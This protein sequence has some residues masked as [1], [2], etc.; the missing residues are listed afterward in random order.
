MTK[1]QV[2]SIF[3]KELIYGLIILLILNLNFIPETLEDVIEWTID[4]LMIHL[5]F[6]L[7]FVLYYPHLLPLFQQPLTPHNLT[8]KMSLLEMYL[9]DSQHNF[10]IFLSP[11]PKVR[12]LLLILPNLMFL[13]FHLLLPLN[14]PY[15]LS[16][17]IITL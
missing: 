16:T 15:P 2:L 11:K 4:L 10:L 7:F 3:L 13:H 1:A 12:E 8:L 14:L 17:S 6:I 9:P 5:S